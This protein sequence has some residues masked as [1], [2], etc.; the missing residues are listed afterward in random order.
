MIS[1]RTFQLCTEYQQIDMSRKHRPT[2]GPATYKMLMKE[3][4]ETSPHFS[5]KL[6]C[7]WVEVEMGEPLD[8]DPVS[9]TN[10]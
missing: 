3:N 6:G 9:I 1:L 7:E 2:E 5:R 10:H 8:F 4:H